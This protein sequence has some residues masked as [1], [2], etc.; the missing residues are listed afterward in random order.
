MSENQRVKITVKKRI[1][2]ETHQIKQQNL[3]K[4]YECCRDSSNYVK[5]DRLNEH[6]YQNYKCNVCGKHLYAANESTEE[7]QK[8]HV[9]TKYNQQVKELERHVLYLEWLKKSCNAEGKECNFVNSFCTLC[10]RPYFQACS[11][12]NS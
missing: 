7:Q 8:L 12:W 3:T 4:Q 1:P 9:L 5:Y 10:N 6:G 11:Y 2:S